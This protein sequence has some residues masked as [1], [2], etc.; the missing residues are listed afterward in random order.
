MSSP[1]PFQNGEG[2][3]QNIALK[4]PSPSLP[5]S[6]HPS[7]SPCP[8]GPLSLVISFSFENESVTSQAQRQH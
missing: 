6:L 4:S 7:L 2:L 8:L 5:T 3:S 1:E